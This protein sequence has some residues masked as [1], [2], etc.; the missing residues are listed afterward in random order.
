MLI[1]TWISFASPGEQQYASVLYC[2]K[3]TKLL[4]EKLRPNVADRSCGLDYDTG[5]YGRG[6]GVGRGR[7]TGFDLGVGVGR[8]VEVTVDVGEGV[9]LAVAVGVDVGVDDGVDV[10][11]AVGD[12]VGVGVPPLSSLRQTPSPK[13]PANR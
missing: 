10:T 3:S 9:A 4:R 12:G 11:V 7:G 5:I 1:A 13:A 8:G 2:A 6:G